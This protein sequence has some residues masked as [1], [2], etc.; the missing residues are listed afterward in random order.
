MASVSDAAHAA[1]YA[2][3]P[4]LFDSRECSITRDVVPE[5]AWLHDRMPI[6]LDAAGL[7]TWLQHTAA[8]DA[9]PPLKALRSVLSP[10]DLRWQ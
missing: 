10:G 1:A 3:L 4:L 2:R 8:E 9:E 6:L 7:T 5:L